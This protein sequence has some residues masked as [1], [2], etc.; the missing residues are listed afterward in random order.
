MTKRIVFDVDQTIALAAERYQDCVPNTALIEKIRSLH[1]SGTQIVL[2]SARNMNTHQNNHGLIAAKTLPILVAWLEEHQ[3]P[4]DEIWMGK[5][6]CGH[7]GY[8]V[9]DRAIRPREF[10]ELSEKEISDLLER[11]AGSTSK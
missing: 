9:D 6:W 7:D 4:Y 8:Y 5:P 10:V 3:V 11:D 2:H 1:A